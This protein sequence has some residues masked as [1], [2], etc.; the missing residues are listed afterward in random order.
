MKIRINKLLSAAGVCSRREADRLTD[1]GRVTADGV[2][3]A[4]G[5]KVEET[6]DICIDGKP[7][8][9]E[10]SSVLIAYNKPKGVV[11]TTTDRYGETDIV[12]AVGFD[13]RIYPIG[14]LDKDST[15]LIMLTNNGALMN[16]L[17]KASGQH[18]KEYLVKINKKVTEKFLEKMRGGIYLEELDKT[19]AKCRAWACDKKD[20][21]REIKPGKDGLYDTHTFRIVLIQGLNRQ[22]RRMCDAC[23]ARV[24][25]LKRIRIMN[26]LLGDLP[27]GEYR[28]VEGEEYNALVS[29][30]GL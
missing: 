2:N 27:E 30:L 13:K 6:A 25:S 8:R 26:V 21:D 22:I 14:R 7:I 10:E 4:T 18:E 1:A 16:E 29:A 9:R 24:V 19:T 12:T 20:I 28:M 3:V 23:G 11:C 5:E 15:G 17:T